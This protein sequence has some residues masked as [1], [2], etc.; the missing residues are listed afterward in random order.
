MWKIGRTDELLKMFPDLR[1]CVGAALEEIPG[2][3]DKQKK[4]ARCKTPDHTTKTG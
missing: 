2:P 3:E 1:A 4:K